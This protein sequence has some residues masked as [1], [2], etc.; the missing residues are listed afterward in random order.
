MNIKEVR[1]HFKDA[2]IVECS[3]DK[4]HYKINHS[5]IE[6]VISGC[7]CQDING[8]WVRLSIK[9]KTSKIIKYKTPEKLYT[10]KDK[11]RL[12]V[13]E[14]HRNETYNLKQW[15]FPLT[16]LDEV[17]EVEVTTELV[18]TSLDTT[19]KTII[20]NVDIKISLLNEDPTELLNHVT[21]SVKQ[22]LKN[23]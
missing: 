5:T 8:Y 22:F 10:L 21:K 9:R 6:E 4:K 23:K 17:K 19:N 3:T 7:R 13:V 2:E 20:L 12:L 1:E 14:R 11:Y 16:M 18:G 15:T